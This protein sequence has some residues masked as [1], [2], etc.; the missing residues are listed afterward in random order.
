VRA[1]E[2]IY[3]KIPVSTGWYDPNSGTTPSPQAFKPRKNDISGLSVTRAD[4]VSIE[5]A[6]QGPSPKGYYVAVLRVG[7][8]QARGIDVVA[9]PLEG[10]PGH[11]EIP[12]L[13][14]EGAHQTAGQEI[15]VLLANELALRVEGPFPAVIPQERRT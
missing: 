15:M 5:E 9:A 7:D 3:R 4:F 8:L 12:R 14:Y 6:A 1:E 13:T 10:N 2:Y 11:A